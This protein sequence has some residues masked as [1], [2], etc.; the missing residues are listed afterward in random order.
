MI[1]KVLKRKIRKKLD[2]YLK[3]IINFLDDDDS[4]SPGALSETLNDLSRY[5][6]IVLYKYRKY[7]DEKYFKILLKK[8]ELLEYELNYKLMNINMNLYDLYEEEKT[9]N[10]TR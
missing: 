2:L 10:R 9:S 7:L 8:I 1:E 6:N 5:K 4:S 3:L